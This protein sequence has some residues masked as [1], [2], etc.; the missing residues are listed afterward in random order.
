MSRKQRLVLD[1]VHSD[2]TFQPALWRG[3]IVWAG[4]CI[5]CGARL[6]ISERGDVLNRATIEHIEPRN[7]GGTD[8]LDNIA[9]ACPRCNGGKGIRLDHRSPDDPELRAMVE[10]L[11]RRRAERW[12]DPDDVP[13]FPNDP[14]LLER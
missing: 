5:H 14:R 7:H 1:I 11:Q 2:A 4:K 8:A 9:L 3:V 12:R 6:V 13:L 10:R